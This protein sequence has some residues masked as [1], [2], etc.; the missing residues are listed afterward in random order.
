MKKSIS[1]LIFLTSIQV[2]AGTFDRIQSL[3]AIHKNDEAL[4][5]ILSEI[6]ERSKSIQLNDVV[7]EIQSNQSTQTQQVIT[8]T[9]S[10]QFSENAGGKFSF[11]WFRFNL[12]DK[13]SGSATTQNT[14]WV[15]ANSEEVAKHES[16]LNQNQRSLNQKL[17]QYV[18]ANADQIRQIKLLMAAAFYA[19]SKLP[20]ESV[21]NYQKYLNVISAQTQQFKF[22]GHHKV[23]DCAIKHYAATTSGSNSSRNTGLS[24]TGSYL[25]LLFPNNWLT[26]TIFRFGSD[27][28][29]SSRTETH[30]Y[31][32]TKCSESQK[33]A[34]ID[35]QSIMA[36]QFIQLDRAIDYWSAQ[37]SFNQILNLK[38]SREGLTWGLF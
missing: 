38:P 25:P 17:N 24:V 26:A 22:V 37:L 3:L 1:L 33:M 27:R 23:L 8:S 15:V 12:S 5:I 11:L 6:E 31:S 21:A 29:S 14:T 18:L 35:A 16:Q 13:S 34:T 4:N 32:D 20:S 19:A 30:A 36:I 2:F 28:S 7:A 10:Y 9:N